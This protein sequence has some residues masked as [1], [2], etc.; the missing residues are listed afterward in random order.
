MESLDV[1]IMA[2]R[3]L[4]DD[5]QVIET[6]AEMDAQGCIEAMYWPGGTSAP[7]PQAQLLQE[8]IYELRNQ[9]EVLRGRLGEASVNVK[10]SSWMA[11]LE[12]KGI[13]LEERKEATP[14]LDLRR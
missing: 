4:N 14:G 2:L 5:L 12:D 9:V 11:F 1:A 13:A 10:H 6:L 3:K 7:K 8:R